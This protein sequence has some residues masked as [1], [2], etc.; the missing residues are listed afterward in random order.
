MILTLFFSL[1]AVY[2][3][4]K[5]GKQHDS[6]SDIDDP[7]SLTYWSHNQAVVLS[8][9]RQRRLSVFAITPKKKFR[10]MRYIKVNAKAASSGFLSVF[11]SPDAGPMAVAALNEGGLAVTTARVSGEVVTYLN[12]VI[13]YNGNGREQFR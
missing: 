5:D 12:E 6:F 7:W 4:D 10:H 3:I 11:K 13:V 8:E 9:R 1:F 2:L